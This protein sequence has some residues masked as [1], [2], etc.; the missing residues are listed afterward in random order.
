VKR[1]KRGVEEP[2]QFGSEESAEDS[3]LGLEI[4]NETMENVRKLEDILERTTAEKDAQKRRIE[5]LKSLVSSVKG[6][7]EQQRDLAIKIFR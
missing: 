2:A 6:K 3:K 1:V 5:A 4:Y 7:L